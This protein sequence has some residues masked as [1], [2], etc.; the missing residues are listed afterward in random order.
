MSAVLLSGKAL[1]KT[2]QQRAH[3]EARELEADGLRPTLAVVVAT[4][5]GSTHWYVRSI[6]RAAE[7]AAI[8]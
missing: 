5:D 3:H 7:S 4:D 1:A 6:A 8:S 2:I